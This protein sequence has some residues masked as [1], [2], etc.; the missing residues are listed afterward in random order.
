MSAD[1]THRVLIFAQ[2]EEDLPRAGEQYFVGD[3]A[4]GWF[5]LLA[6]MGPGKPRSNWYLACSIDPGDV[7]D[8]WEPGRGREIEFE[9]RDIEPLNGGLS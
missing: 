1:A 4:R 7:V 9:V 2:R 6:P 5:E 3:N 8:R